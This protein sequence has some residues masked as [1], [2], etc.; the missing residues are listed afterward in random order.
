MNNIYINKTQ[1][2]DMFYAELQDVSAHVKV[3]KLKGHFKN[4]S[5]ILIQRLKKSFRKHDITFNQYRYL[6]TSIKDILH[7]ELNEFKGDKVVAN[8]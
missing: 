1:T 3:S 2:K 5:K 4:M 8:V 7:T 6:T